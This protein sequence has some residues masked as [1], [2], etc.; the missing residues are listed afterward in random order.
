LMHGEDTKQR[1][2]GR[3]AERAPQQNASRPPPPTPRSHTATNREAAGVG[4]RGRPREV[5]GPHGG[6]GDSSRTRLRVRQ[7][8]AAHRWWRRARS[9]ALVEGGARRRLYAHA[10]RARQ[11]QRRGQ[12]VVARARARGAD[13][14][15][16]PRDPGRLNRIGAGG[17]E[18]RRPERLGKPGAGGVACALHGRKTRSAHTRH[19]TPPLPRC[20]TE[21][22]AT[23]DVSA[24]GVAGRRSLGGGSGGGCDRWRQN[25]RE[26]WDSRPD[27]RTRL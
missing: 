12:A 6:A 10:S 17:E 24:D 23:T 1:A 7:P 11:R 16:P 26:R 3:R 4:G 8:V 15:V 21:A 20:A 25:Y 5:R 13:A 18:P 22:A 14:E 27:R 9:G 2:R 19:A